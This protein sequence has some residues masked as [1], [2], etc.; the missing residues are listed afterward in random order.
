M[1]KAKND[2]L[3]I[4]VEEVKSKFA[5]EKPKPWYRAKVLSIGELVKGNY[6]EGENVL[7]TPHATSLI[8][9]NIYVVRE[10]SVL[11]CEIN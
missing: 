9:D 8:I 10:S 11:A 7:V 1:Y 6:T 5:G 4:E 3:L 2:N